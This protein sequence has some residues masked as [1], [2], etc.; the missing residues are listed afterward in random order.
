MG[1]LLISSVL[2]LP[3][4]SA[5]RLFKNFKSVTLFASF[6]AVFG[7]ITGLFVSFWLGIPTGACIV[8]VNFL[9]FVVALGVNKCPKFL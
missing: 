5:L 6:L 9:I 1:A 3:T 8:I 2:I 4:L 7:F